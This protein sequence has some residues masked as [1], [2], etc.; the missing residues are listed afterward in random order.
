M[1]HLGPE[2]FKI[3]IA[4]QGNAEMAMDKTRS[5]PLREFAPLAE[6]PG[7]RMVVLQKGA[8]IEQVADAPFK[9]RLKRSETISTPRP[10]FWI[11]PRS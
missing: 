4:W 11:R 1:Q 2:G 6:L 9:E 3:G 8:G 10:H 7:V 5:I